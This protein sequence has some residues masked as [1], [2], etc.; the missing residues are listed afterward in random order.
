[1][2]VNRSYDA[3]MSAMTINLNGEELVPLPAG[4]LYWPER[5]ALIVA[6]LHFEKGSSFGARGVMLPPYD[7]RTT[8][9][10]LAAIA[11]EMKPALIISLGDAFHDRGSEVRMDVDDAALLDDLISVHDWLW[12][13][14][15]HDPDP[16]KRFGGVVEKQT[17][18]GGL[19]LTHE[20]EV[21]PE[22]GE[23]AGHLHPCARVQT[24]NKTLRR[25]CFVTDGARMVLPAFGAY[26]GGLNILDE[27]FAPLF[28]DMTAWVMGRDDVY[29]IARS[30]L[31]PDAPALRRRAG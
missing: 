28:T 30:N 27:A 29:P 18:V 26:T 16:P 6:D 12:I 2:M 4:A 19:F 17:L 9:R 3:P 1:M 10:R 22:A 14:G 8:L 15:N 13:L 20:P 25:R 24:G 21:A 23:L 5:Q 7:T 11:R 31:A